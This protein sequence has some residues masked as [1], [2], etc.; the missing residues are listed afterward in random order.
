MSRP[1]FLVA[2]VLVLSLLMATSFVAADKPPAKKADDPFAA[3]KAPAKKSG[4][5]APA[6]APLKKSRPPAAKRRP[7]RSGEAAI[8]EALAKPTE[9]ECVETPLTDVIDAL[10]NRCGI[11][12]QLHKKALDDVGIGTDT[13]VTI[14]LR[15]VPLRSALNLLLR[16]LSLTWTIRDEVLLITTPEEDESQMI[17]KVYD[18]SDLVVCRDEHGVLWDDYDTLIDVITTTFLPTGWDC[19]GGP[20]AIAGASLGKAKVLVVLQTRD[21]HYQIASLLAEVRQVAKKNPD[22]QIPLRNRPLPK[23]REKKPPAG[24]CAFP[25]TSPAPSKPAAGN[26]T[27]QTTLPPAPN[28]AKGKP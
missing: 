10:K 21:V 24:M 3:D 16:G 11:E 8:E 14:D 22:A 1:R 4:P 23:A 2:S 26:P 20:G 5:S 13:P 12:I 15:G 25:G 19:D 27:G 9:L 28:T 6:K 18:V 7:L 17:R